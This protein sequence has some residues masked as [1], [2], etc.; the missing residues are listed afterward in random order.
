[1]YAQRVQRQHR[2]GF[3]HQS[4]LV[5]RHYYGVDAFTVART[6]LH[7]HPVVGRQ[8]KIMGCSRFGLR[9]R[10]SGHHHPAATHQV[11]DQ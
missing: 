2:G 5:R 1:M 6:N 7:M 4:P 3:R 9:Q 10:L 8:R 11:I